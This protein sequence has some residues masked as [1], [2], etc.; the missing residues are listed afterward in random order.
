MKEADSLLSAQTV[1]G[2]RPAELRAE[3]DPSCLFKTELCWGGGR[4]EEK[5]RK[6]LCFFLLFPE[7]SLE[8]TGTKYE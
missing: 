3:S 2:L 8:G 5:D 1:L 4:V 6:K 7:L